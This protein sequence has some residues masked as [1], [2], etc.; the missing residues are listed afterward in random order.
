MRVLVNGAGGLVGGPLADRMERAGLDVVRSGRTRRGRGWLVWDMTGPAST[1]EDRFDCVVHAAPL[2]LL[3]DHMAA[4]AAAGV[5]RLVAFGSTSA[6]TKRQSASR[7]DR[8][9]ASSLSRAEER[10]A[11][12]SARL[13]MNM[14]LFRPT[15]VYGYGRDEN[16]STIARFARR[17]GFFPVAGRAAGRRQPVHA[18]DLVNAVMAALDEAGTFGRTYN[19]TGGETLTYRAMVARIFEGL[20]RPARI[21][22]VPTALYGTL[23]AAAGIVKQG[24]SPSMAGRMNQDM[25]FDASR[26]RADFGFDPQGF[27]EHPER[28]LPAP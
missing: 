1:L 21:F 28:D 12:E 5:A 10:L 14:T 19:L 8:A 3:P 22:S 17:Y 23:L 13:G 26:A 4:L 27:L 15:M 24:V 11:E 18:D 16:I 20:G 6:L 25:V 9:L 2:W 7:A